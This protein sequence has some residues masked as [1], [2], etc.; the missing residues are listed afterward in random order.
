MVDAELLRKSAIEIAAGVRAGDYSALELTETALRA[1]EQLDPAIGAFTHVD[2][3]RALAAAGQ[4]AAGDERPFAGVPTAIKD[5]GALVEGM[6][7][8]CGSRLFGDY[9][10]PLDTAIVR[11]IKASGMVILGK[12]NT[13]EFGILPVT[14]PVRHGP[15]RNPLDPSRTAGGS[16][17]GAA[18]AV[19][20]GML[21]VAHG[22]D[23]AG[24]LRIPAACCGL[25]GLKP[26]RNRVSGAPTQAENHTGTQ[27]FIARSV[28]D[29]AATLDVIAGYEPG[30]A[31]WAPEPAEPF[32]DSARRDP[33]KLRIGVVTAPTVEL[34][35]A[36]EHL[37]AL[38]TTAELLSGAGHVVEE[39][40]L[41]WTDQRMLE[42]FVESSCVSVAGAVA[43]AARVSGLEP[44]LETIEALTYEFWLRGREVLAVD[45]QAIEAQLKMFARGVIARASAYD[46]ILTPVLNQRPVEIGRIDAGLGMEAFDRAVEFTSFT[47]IVN[48]T[49]LPAIALPTGIAADGLPLAIQLI[50]RPAGEGPLLALAAQFESLIAA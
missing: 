37:A 25:V 34:P 46:A 11:R 5:I 12:T 50:G 3:E 27:G 13:P 22:T 4:I 39:A 8:H 28:A 42:L 18:A 30:D 16:S 26:S 21:P 23:G 1:I 17:G 19:A 32:A 2:A 47:A 20:A 43:S 24:S 48:Q 41:G 9:T 40:D 44:S 6:P 14:E 31:N 33:G 10:A 45:H 49:G 29:A 15:T 35:V 7:F 38:R 36:D